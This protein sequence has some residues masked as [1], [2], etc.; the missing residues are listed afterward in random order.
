[1]QMT[2][3]EAA[4][5][6]NL[7]DVESYDPKRSPKDKPRVAT[8]REVIAYARNLA[9]R[10]GLY[11]FEEVDVQAAS[12]T[13]GELSP[14]R[15]ER[16]ERVEAT[17]QDGAY[18]IPLPGAGGGQR[19]IVTMEMLDDAGAV[20]SS[21]TMPTT[22]KRQVVWDKDA[23]ARAVGPVEKV[24]RP[25]KVKPAMS[26]SE[27]MRLYCEQRAA[28]LAAEAPA[29]EM[30]EPVRLDANWQEI[31]PAMEMSECELPP[32]V[33][34]IEGNVIAV[35]FGAS[36]S[37]CEHVE[38]IEAVQRG[39][40]PA[41][42]SSASEAEP[43]GQSEPNGSVTI[44]AAA[45]AAL[46]ARIEALESRLNETKSEPALK[47]AKIDENTNVSVQIAPNARGRAREA[48]LRLVRRYLAMRTE[49]KQL[50]AEV[51]RAAT[52]MT[53]RR[54]AVI[55]A[56]EMRNTASLDRSA[57]AAANI[58][59]ERMQSRALK[60]EER[61]EAAE[62]ELSD[63]RGKLAA[64]EVR[65]SQAEERAAPL[66][67]QKQAR[68]IALENELLELKSGGRIKMSIGYNQPRVAF[69]SALQ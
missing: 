50:R 55:R 6:F 46:V 22:D 59:C 23:V 9:S 7:F 27:V 34:M 17:Y 57:L 37:L 66:L 51:R 31:A 21:R 43:A 58:Y 19:E 20:M 35:D 63:I 45:F 64:S 53:K 38:P 25:R 47:P 1:M 52:V 8:E 62:F 15:Y 49:R 10:A 54:R 26:D 14:I 32:A 2:R 13:F 12:V 16:G 40:Q 39:K 42:L 4:P 5:A 29:V 24:K 67:D 41:P 28:E 65:A 44:P 3:I 33:E 36:R 18:S 48:R 68:I 61:A 56:M 69:Q 60:A 11:P 30:P